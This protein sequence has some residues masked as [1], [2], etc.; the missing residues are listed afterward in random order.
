MT[1][2]Y[3][4]LEEHQLQ[5]TLI[6]RVLFCVLGIGV[7]GLQGSYIQNTDIIFLYCLIIVNSQEGSVFNGLP[8]TK[9]VKVTSQLKKDIFFYD[10]IIDKP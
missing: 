9:D 6:F 3:Q 7:F 4:L 1:N 2:F 5:R 8:S 10:R